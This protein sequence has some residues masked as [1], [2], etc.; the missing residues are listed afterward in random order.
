MLQMRLL[1]QFDIRVDGKRVLIPSRSGQ[2]LFAYLVLTAGTAQRRKNLRGHCGRI[3]RMKMRAESA[4][5]TVA[6]PESDPDP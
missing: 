3:S 6:H 1:G 5:G 2:S 4:S